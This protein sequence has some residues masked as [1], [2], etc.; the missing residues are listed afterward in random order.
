MARA[1]DGELRGLG[2]PFF[3]IRHSLVLPQLDVPADNT[4]TSSITVGAG[5]KSAISRDEL[6]AFQ[7]RMLD[8][9]EDLCKES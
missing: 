7:K 5:S 3:A 8:L 4:P 1:L 2:I 9:L 6:V